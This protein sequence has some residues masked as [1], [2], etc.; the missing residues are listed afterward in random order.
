MADFAENSRADDNAIFSIIDRMPIGAYPDLD[1]D[2][3]AGNEILGSSEALQAL[4][5]ELASAVLKKEG[6]PASFTGELYARFTDNAEM[7]QLN[8]G[9]R[10]K[11]KP[12]NILSFPGVE[13]DQVIAMMQEAAFDGPPVILGDL[14]LAVPV[15]ISE[16]GDQKK[17]V[18]HH[19]SHLIVHGL[20]H[21][22]GYDH[23]EDDEA[24]VMEAKEREI[25]A[26]FDI[27]DPYLT[28]R[29][30]G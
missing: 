11:D 28:E 25:L 9:F 24:E 26:D 2:V 12:T 21:L 3:D 13:P 20:L 1:V 22:L 17:P 29:A 4:L 30:D 8:K 18:I 14:V 6:V 7:Q 5:C 16:A 19:L 27:S 15:V 23:I 10:G